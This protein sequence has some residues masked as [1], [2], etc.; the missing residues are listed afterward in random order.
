MRG[1]FALAIASHQRALGSF[2]L[3][4][5]VKLLLGLGKS[6]TNHVRASKRGDRHA[7]NWLDRRRYALR[8]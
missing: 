1:W 7:E 6:C 3:A 4:P 2:H 8:T 5:G